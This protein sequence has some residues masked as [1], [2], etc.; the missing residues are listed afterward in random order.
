MVPVVETF[1]NI[2]T[3]RTDS[4]RV[5]GFAARHLKTTLWCWRY[6]ITGNLLSFF[7]FFCKFQHSSDEVYYGNGFSF[8]ILILTVRVVGFYLTVEFIIM[9]ILLWC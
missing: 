1:S 3:L 7:F 5:S 2:K 8:S 4:Y 6:V 9:Y